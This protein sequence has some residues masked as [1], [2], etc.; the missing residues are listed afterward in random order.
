MTGTSPSYETLVENAPMGVFQVNVDKDHLDDTDT[1][2]QNLY[3]NETLADILSFESREDF[4]SNSSSVEYE[5]PDDREELMVQLEETGHVKAFETALVTNNGNTVEVL[6]SGS[7]EDDTL[8][9]Y[10]TDITKR[11]RLERKA[12]KQAEA[13]LEQSTP[14]VQI[15]EGIT[16]ATVIGTLDTRRAQRL[17]EQLLTDITE[18]QSEIALIDITGV[19]NVDTA[20][21]QHI[22]DTVNAVSL[23]GSEVIIT[24]LNPDIAQTLVQLGITMN[25]IRTK[26]SLSDGLE[27]GLHLI[28][29]DVPTTSE[30]R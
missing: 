17:T 20:T 10:V 9:G 13:I 19:P 15:W 3:V 23:L 28:D 4:H 25:N 18:N 22:I 27:L 2:Q 5:N 8:T 24:G 29:E 12:A 26:S 14:I 6:I 7:L 16:L 21:A 11:K 1:D 30:S